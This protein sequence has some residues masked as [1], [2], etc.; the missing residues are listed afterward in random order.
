MIP[1][2]IHF[3]WF[4][5]GILP[6]K[7]KK[8]ID[9]WKKYCADYEFIEWNE[10]NFDTKQNLYVEQAYFA[11]KYAFV[12][13][14]VRLYALCFTG[15][16]YMDTDVE[17]LKPLDDYL[18]NQAFS[19]FEQP[20]A[21]PTGIMACEKGFPLFLEFLNYYDDKKFIKDDGSYDNTTNVKIITEIMCR[22]GLKLNGKHQI[23]KG[24]AIYPKEIFCPFDNG[25]GLLKRT[26]DTVTI[27]WFA[28]SWCSRNERIKLFFSRPFHRLFGT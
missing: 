3:C 11:K 9:S 17:L 2:I 25:T 27:H 26:V 10:N 18:S 24:F 5:Q 7:N 28:K 6:K 8:C 19:G 15:G 20:N 22:Y 21:I 16:I 23:I 12:A 14:Y 1:R 13:D 4:G